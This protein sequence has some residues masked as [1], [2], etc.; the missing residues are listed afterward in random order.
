MCSSRNIHTHWRRSLLLYPPLPSNNRILYSGGG[1]GCTPYSPEFPWFFPLS[2]VL[3]LVPRGWATCPSHVLSISM[4]QSINQSIWLRDC[5]QSKQLLVL[6]T[7]KNHPPLHRKL[8]PFRSPTEPPQNLRCLPWGG[9][10]MDIYWNYY[11]C[12]KKIMF[13]RKEDSLCL[14]KSMLRQGKLWTIKGRYYGEDK[15]G[16]QTGNLDLRKTN[17]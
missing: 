7:S 4:N 9:E 11:F 12:R 16:K 3:P 15:H 5:S 10:D 13:L 14:L 2:W 1:G 8:P 17:K 6:E